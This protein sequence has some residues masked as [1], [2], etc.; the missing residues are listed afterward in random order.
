MSLGSALVALL[1]VVEFSVHQV[2]KVGLALCWPG[3]TD[4]TVAGHHRGLCGTPQSPRAYW[5]PEDVVN[6]WEY[7]KSTTRNNEKAQS[8][9]Q[10]RRSLL[11]P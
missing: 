8:N 10:E 3:K 11:Q 9:G 7:K 5:V 6:I 2:L 4:R 1:R